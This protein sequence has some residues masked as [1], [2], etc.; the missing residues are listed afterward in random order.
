M[1]YSFHWSIIERLPGEMGW[2]RGCGGGGGGEGVKT[3]N[4]I[5]LII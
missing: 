1:G 3:A 4:K 2:G 5:L